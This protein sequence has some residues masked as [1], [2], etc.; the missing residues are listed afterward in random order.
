MS[1]V[2][3]NLSNIADKSFWEKPE[4]KT[5]LLFILAGLVGGGFALYKLLPYIILILQ[6]TLHA[7]LLGAAL[8]VLTSPIWNSN[9]RT[10]TVYMFRSVMRAITGFFVEIDPIGILKN[11]I[12]DLVK[13]QSVMEQQISNL[14][15]HIQRVQGLIEKNANESRHS[16]KLAAAAKEQE[17]RSAFVLNARK[18]GRLEQSNVTLQGMLTKMQLLYKNLSKLREVSDIMIQDMTNEVEV[19]EQERNAIRASYGAFTAAMKILRGDPDKRA[20]YDQA[21]DHLADDYARKVGEIENFME[22]SQGF[23]A[24]V[25]LDNLVF[26]QEALEKLELLERKT[27]QFLSG[28]VQPHQIPQDNVHALFHR[29]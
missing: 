28:G 2:H 1:D 26:E 5:G 6:N 11:Y 16:M 3:D 15:G 18:A 7:S 19:K 29:S 8:V 27:D 14:K 20:L 17:Q 23:I 13:N 24:S 10:L 12:M 25:D 21:M 9:I 4:G 22:V